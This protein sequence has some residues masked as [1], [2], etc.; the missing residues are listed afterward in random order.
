MNKIKNIILLMTIASGMFAFS[1]VVSAAPNYTVMADFK[2]QAQYGAN[3]VGG[4][5]GKS[6]P[7]IVSTIVNILSFIVGTV[8]VIM[9]VISGLR[10]VTSGGDANKVSSAKSALTYALVGVIVAA[11]AQFIVHYVIYNASG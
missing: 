1:P 3:Q 7:N 8:A 6:V 11:L 10:Y 2:S 5:Q 9:I 4:G